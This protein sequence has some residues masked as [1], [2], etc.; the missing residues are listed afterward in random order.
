M[1]CGMHS[2]HRKKV[3][4]PKPKKEKS[5][6]KF[7]LDAT[8]ATLSLALLGFLVGVFASALAAPLMI[9]WKLIFE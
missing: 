8:K 4:T 7:I 6:M 3:E 5:V 1:S 9:V 2:H